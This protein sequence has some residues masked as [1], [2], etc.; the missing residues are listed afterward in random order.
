MYSYCIG[1]MYLKQK[2]IEDPCY[3]CVH[4]SEYVPSKKVDFE[5]VEQN[6]ETEPI[7]EY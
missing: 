7:E 5:N 2:E 6:P 3:R 4:G 1:C